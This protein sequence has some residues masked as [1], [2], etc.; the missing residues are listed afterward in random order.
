MAGK[1]IPDYRRAAGQRLAAA[2]TL[3]RYGHHLDSKYLGGYVAECA[4]KALILHRTPVSQRAKVFEEISEGRKCH[5]LEYLTSV[6]RKTKCVLPVEVTQQ[7]RRMLQWTTDWRY[8][9]KWVSFEDATAF[10]EAAEE[11]QAW[12]ERSW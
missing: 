12:V 8:E 10:L 6:L 9:V 5:N 11:M 4:L 2:Q 7:L 1:K 3:V